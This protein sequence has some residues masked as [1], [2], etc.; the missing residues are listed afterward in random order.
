MKTNCFSSEIQQKNQPFSR[1]KSQPNPMGKNNR[2]STEP[3][4]MGIALFSLG[5]GM[6]EC[7]CGISPENITHM[8]RRNEQLLK[9][10]LLK[11]I[12]HSCF[13]FF[14]CLFFF[15]SFIFRSCSFL[16]NMWVIFHGIQQERKHPTPRSCCFSR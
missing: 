1:G 15:K 9:M 16:L 10:K 7:F 13:F 4:I 14:S 2:A 5:V 12:F 8:S 6:F 3:H 11:N